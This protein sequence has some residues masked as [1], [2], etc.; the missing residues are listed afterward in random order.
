MQDR[1]NAGSL[2]LSLHPVYGE[3]EAYKGPERSGAWGGGQ[4]W[5]EEALLVSILE[6]SKIRMREVPEL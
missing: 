1:Q 6:E 2:L 5:V 3:T 4:G